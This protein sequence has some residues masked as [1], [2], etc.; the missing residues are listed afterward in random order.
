MGGTSPRFN[1]FRGIRQ[2]CP[3]SPY[4]IVAL[5]LADHIKSSAV[6]GIS[7]IGQELVIT[8]FTDDTTLF[9]QNENQIPVAIDVIRKASGLFLNINKCE[10][11]DIKECS[12]STIHDIPIKSEILYL[13]FL[14]IKDQQRRMSLNFNPV[15]QTTPP[16]KKN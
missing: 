2:G 8:Q 1:L 13:G 16:P 12:K 10:L 11:L 5:L 3:T 7:L 9:L 14:V 6:K 4:L 15:V